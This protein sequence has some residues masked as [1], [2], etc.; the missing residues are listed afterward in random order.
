MAPTGSH[1]LDRPDSLFA[2][3]VYAMHWPESA[4]RQILAVSPALA[5]HLIAQAMQSHDRDQPDLLS[6]YSECISY[7]QGCTYT[8]YG[9]RSQAHTKTRR[10]P[11]SQ[12]PDAD[13]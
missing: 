13:R 10:T 5:T 6:I 4:Y 7:Y 1:V 2:Q 9:R 3:S 8:A 12:P 11:P